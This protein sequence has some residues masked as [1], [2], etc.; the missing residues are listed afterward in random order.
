VLAVAG[1]RVEGRVVDQ[2]GLALPGVTVRIAAV[3]VGDVQ[4]AVTGGNG[5]YTFELEPGQ[6]R[7][8]ASLD[9]FQPASREVRVDAA[10]TLQDL[11]LSLGHFAQETTVVAE[12]PTE[13]QPRQFGAPA[14][15]SE[16]VIDNAPLRTNRYDDLLPLLPNVVRGARRPGQRGGRACPAGRGVVERGAGH[17]RG[18]R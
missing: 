12:L 9:G 13:I 18:E 1:V 14:T 5:E 17:G 15:I 16:K 10:A 3:P 2:S 7:L 8:D 6:Y 11:V 4:T